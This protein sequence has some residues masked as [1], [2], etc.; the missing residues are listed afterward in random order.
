MSMI[1][2]P[3]C[4]RDISNRAE[5]CPGCGYPISAH[6]DD[7]KNRP[8]AGKRILLS[9][10]IKVATKA[11]LQIIIAAI[12]ILSLILLLCRFC[13]FKGKWY[14]CAI[15]KMPIDTREEYENVKDCEI[16]FKKDSFEIKIGDDFS[17]KGLYEKHGDILILSV[18]DDEDKVTGVIEG[19][20]I[21][22]DMGFD[23]YY[24]SKFKSKEFEY[25]DFSAFN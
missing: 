2:C 4:G 20:I 21:M 8:K 11:R 1:K 17:E 23:D 18:P 9:D 13:G 24:F 3:E 14:L 5:K 7:I 22:L 19:S 12:V 10:I 15:N 25:Y 16:I 6:L